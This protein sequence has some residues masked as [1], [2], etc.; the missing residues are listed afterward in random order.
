LTEK[1]ISFNLRQ[2]FLTP[3]C[4]PG[5][6]LQELSG[7]YSG[8]CGAE[9]VSQGGTLTRIPESSVVPWA[10]SGFPDGRLPHFVYLRLRGYVMAIEWTDDLAV[11]IELIDNQHKDLFKAVNDLT[12]AMWD[13]RGRE[14]AQKV[15][16]FLAQYVILHF[17]AEESLMVQK[18][19]PRY[20]GH[21]HLH[22]K[23]VEDFIQFKAKFDAGESDANSTVR[24][25]DGTCDWLRNHIKKNDK[26]L[27]AFLRQA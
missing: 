26:E 3:Q 18:N 19:Y 22:D 23:F 1:A 14:Q 27:G 15:L 16:E 8:T 13:G 5:I 21:K 4:S 6:P 7:A 10:G 9:D 2:T 20:T 25:L 12:E 24:I 17:G 11:G